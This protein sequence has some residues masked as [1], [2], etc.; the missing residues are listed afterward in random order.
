MNRHNSNTS[1]GS[2]IGTLVI[3]EDIP[4]FESKRPP[5]EKARARKQSNPKQIITDNPSSP[6][7]FIP[8]IKEENIPS[9]EPEINWVRSLWCSYQGPYCREFD[10]FEELDLHEK[11]YHSRYLSKECPKCM[12]RFLEDKQLKHHLQYTCSRFC[13]KIES[14]STSGSSSLSRKTRRSLTEYQNQNS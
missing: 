13:P 12:M 3:D 8:E 11:L 5:P 9:P 4:R 7:F 6:E 1:E 2:S 14:S 10:S